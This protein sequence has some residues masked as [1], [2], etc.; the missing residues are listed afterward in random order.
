[1]PLSESIALH[2]ETLMGDASKVVIDKSKSGPN[3][4]SN[5]LDFDDSWDDIEE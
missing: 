5:E 2:A 1:M 3:S 4:L